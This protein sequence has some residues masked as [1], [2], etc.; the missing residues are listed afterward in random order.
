MRLLGRTAITALRLHILLRSRCRALL[1]HRLLHG[2][3]RLTPATLLATHVLAH[4][5]TALRT[6]TQHLHH[7]SE[8]VDQHFSGVALLAALILPFAGLQFA[9]H[10]DLGALL[11]VLASHFGQLAHED[12]AVPFGTLFLLTG[13]LVAPGFGGS[14]SNVG[15]STATRHVA[16]F[17]VLP[18]VTDQNDF[19]D[20]STGHNLSSTFIFRPGNAWTH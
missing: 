11:Q 19:I 12:D 16:Y 5:L 20:A 3:L 7:A 15:H 4:T 10:I 1:I 8:A 9:F 13:L 18:E 14:Q 17:R 2:L 6:T